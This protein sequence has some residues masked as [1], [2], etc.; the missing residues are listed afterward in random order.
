MNCD[1]NLNFKTEVFCKENRKI[2]DQNI[3]SKLKA[4]T[5]SSICYEQT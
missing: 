5:R 1:E 3:L 2:Q 4:K